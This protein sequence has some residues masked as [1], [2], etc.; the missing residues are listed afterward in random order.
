MTA[1]EFNVL[2][3]Q[4]IQKI[5]DTLQYKATEYASD[6]RLHNFKSDVGGLQL[7]ESPEQVCWGYLRKHLQSIYDMVTGLK[8]PTLTMINEKIGDGINYLI[9]LEAILIES[10]NTEAQKKIAR[11][12][13]A[14][15]E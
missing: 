7:D 11:T 2:L 14:S 13:Y 9:L 3:E 10:T 15:T 4:R 5:R 1:Q 12:Q 8:K 6:D